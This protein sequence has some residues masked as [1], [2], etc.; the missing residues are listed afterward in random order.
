MFLRTA[1]LKKE[2]T[3]ALKSS[4]L[5]VGMLDGRYYVRGRNWG[6]FADRESVS[7]KFKGAVTEL[8][9]RLPEPGEINQYM[10]DKD[11]MRTSAYELTFHPYEAWLG[12]KERIRQTPVLLDAFPHV[13]AVFQRKVTLELIAVKQTLINAISDKELEKEEVMPGDPYLIGCGML[14]WHN[15]T[16]IYWAEAERM[17]E[18]VRDVLFPALMNVDFYADDWRRARVEENETA[19]ALPLPYL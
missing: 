7:N 11:G 10:Q 16:T 14:C 2:M 3:A 15:E 4:G 12:A 18:K 6:L 1:E 19:G 17:A 8:V 9:G 5:V 13:Y